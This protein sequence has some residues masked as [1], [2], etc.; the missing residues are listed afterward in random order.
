M[1]ED[2]LNLVT[3]LLATYLADGHRCPEYELIRWLQAPEQGIF[4]EDALSDSMTL[5]R[6]NFIVM[7]A[8]YRLRNR[9][10]EDARGYLQISALD[11]GLVPLKTD[12]GSDLPD[13]HD[14]L[15]EYYLDL[16]NLDTDQASVDAL[17]N[18]FW[19]R[20][21][22]PEHY[23]NDLA[24]LELTPP[25]DLSTIRQQYRRLASQH[26]PDKGGDAEAFRKVSSAYQRLRY[27]HG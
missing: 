1:E 23:D 15:A 19:Q 3:D 20:M 5:F 14:A 11:I 27:R 7:H 21:V 4:R 9:W 2:T 25:V 16:N 10:L 6:A 22:I 18:D 24:V 26:H 17:L 13:Q 8:L 12:S